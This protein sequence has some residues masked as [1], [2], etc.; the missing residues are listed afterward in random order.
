MQSVRG[1]STGAHEAVR[2]HV[3]RARFPIFKGGTKSVASAIGPTSEYRTVGQNF[4]LVRRK[5]A[6]IHRA[7]RQLP[8]CRPVVP[9]A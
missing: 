4:S 5:A 2:V 3:E 6:D 8:P 9:E 7:A 1:I